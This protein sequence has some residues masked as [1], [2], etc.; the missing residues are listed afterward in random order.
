MSDWYPWEDD[1][2]DDEG[3]ICVNLGMND[4]KGGCTPPN[5]P[6]VAICDSSSY[7][8]DPKID[9]WRFITP[10]DVFGPIEKLK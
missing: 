6:Q 8:F 1:F 2:D 9:E 7:I 3:C 4:M 5:V 10:E